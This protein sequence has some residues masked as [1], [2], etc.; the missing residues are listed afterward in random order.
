[1]P[2]PQA[3]RTLMMV[4]SCC[5]TDTGGKAYADDAKV[6]AKATAIDLIIASLP[7]SSSFRDFEFNPF[8][9]KTS[10]IY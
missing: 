9:T 1:M 6:R 5:G 7:L 4:R 10:I 2:A 3:S 8:H